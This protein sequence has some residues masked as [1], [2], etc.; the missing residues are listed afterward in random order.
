MQSI[1]ENWLLL[2]NLQIDYSIKSSKL[3]EILLKNRGLTT[4]KEIDLFLHSKLSD[5]NTKSLEIKS[6]EL[7]K[8]VER[9][10]KAM[11]QKETIVV[12]GDYDV[13][14]ITSTAILWET[15]YA[16]G[17]NVIPYIPHRIDEGYGLS[18]KGI[19]SILKEQKVKLIVT[20]DNGIVAQ[21]AVEYAN[22][23]GIDVI[24]TDHHLPDSGDAKLP[25]AFAIVHTTKLCGAGVAWFL[26]KQLGD[27]K[28]TNS[29]LELAALGTIADLVPLVDANRV[30]VKEGL[31]KLRQTKRK[32][33]IALLERSGIKKENVGVYEISHIIAPRLNAMGRIE[34]AMESLRLICTTNQK[35]AQDLADKLNLTNRQRQDLTKV[36]IEHARSLVLSESL[37]KRLLFIAD[38][39][40][41][42][43]IVGLIAGRLT[44]EFY[45]PSIVV[46]VG[47]VYSKA[48]ARSVKGFNIVEFIRQASEYLVD[49]G[50]HPM[51][52][53][54]TVETAKLNILKNT[55]SELAL[56]Q[57]SDEHL[58]RTLLIDLKFPLYLISESLYEAIQ[59]LSP[60]GMG[61]NEPLFVSENVIVE[62]VRFVGNES[63]HVK[64]EVFTHKSKVYEA[65]GFGLSKKAM[66][67]KVGD[68]I[69]IV[70]TISQNTWNNR[71]ILQ[72]KLKDIRTS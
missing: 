6:K 37:N 10:K 24:V 34:H 13:D 31:H 18:I 66:Q 49:I 29:H 67:I 59:Q 36:A 2:S 16:K 12:Y 60:F 61:N 17:A 30:I 15:L 47:E 4:K 19:D 55:L 53:G 3:V 8:A 20:V 62:N 22:S 33:L 35:R 41:Q 26:A 57:V 70:Y 5:I 65:I 48:S 9:I 50:G 11:A 38:S 69:D 40:Y 14:G 32:G 42:Q 63:Q 54:F 56:S 45:L 52:A 51:A 21:S 7:D 46:S 44:E 25:K 28:L 58:V 64:L 72:L 71:T 68:K 23:K 39:S 43:G 1:K 27:E